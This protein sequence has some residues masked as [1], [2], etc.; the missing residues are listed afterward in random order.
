MT[1]TLYSVM[2]I[3]HIIILNVPNDLVANKVNIV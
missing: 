3:L 2:F 1:N